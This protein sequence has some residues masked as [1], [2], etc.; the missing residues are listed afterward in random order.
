MPL[1]K[2]TGLAAA[3][4]I[5]LSSLN[6]I[7]G[8]SNESDPSLSTDSC[9]IYFASDSGTASSDLYRAQRN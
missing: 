8:G 4:A 6:T 7:G 5:A 2:D 3:A 9:T 1:S